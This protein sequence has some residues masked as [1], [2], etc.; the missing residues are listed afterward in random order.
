MF[1]ACGFSFFSVALFHL[2]NH[3]F[4]KAL[5]FLS[6]GAI[7]HALGDEQDMRKMGHLARFLPFTLVAML[8]ASL[9]IMGFPFLT[10]FY[11]KD[12]ILE[13]LLASYQVHSF[14]LYSLALF[15]AFLT[16]TYSFRLL[17]FVFFYRLNYQ[18][19]A[20]PQESQMAISFSLF[21]LA[22]ASLIVGS[23]FSDF[24]VG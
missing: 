19:T 16:A 11:S 21:I 8:F 5:L 14:F 20:L 18:R 4:F 9:A 7:I 13:L 3:A 12:L 10:G 15:A 23:L 17:H 24:Y 2:F 1:L 22:L 6:A